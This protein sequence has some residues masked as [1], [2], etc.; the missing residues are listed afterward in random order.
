MKTLTRAMI[1]TTLALAGQ[2]LV[3]PVLAGHLSIGGGIVFGGG[4]EHSAWQVGIGTGGIGIGVAVG[5]GYRCAP[6]AA[7]VIHSPPVVVHRPM[8]VHRPVVYAPVVVPAPVVYTPV[9]VAVPAPV[10]PAR[11][12]RVVHYLHAHQRI[13]QPMVHGATAVMEVRRNEAYPWVVVSEHP[14][15]W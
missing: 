11:R 12:A 3:S 10:V 5:G 14:S 1:C 15:I 8:V 9:T 13:A 2:A 7:V 4:G 6:P